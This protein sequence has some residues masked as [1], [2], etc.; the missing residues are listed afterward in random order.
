MSSDTFGGRSI[1]II[2]LHEGKCCFSFIT[3]SFPDKIRAS[4]F[5]LAADPGR[6]G[7]RSFGRLPVLD[8]PS[9]IHRCSEVKFNVEPVL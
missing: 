9:Q 6:A 1:K 2:T 8:L 3:I 5:V 4:G 7:L